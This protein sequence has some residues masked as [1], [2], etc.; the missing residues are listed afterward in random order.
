[1]YLMF[2]ILIMR[3]DIKEKLVILRNKLFYLDYNIFID[4]F[5]AFIFVLY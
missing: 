3:L 4:F 1:M 2:F 5:F